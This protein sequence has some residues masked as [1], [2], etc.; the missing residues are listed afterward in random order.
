M[1][2]ASVSGLTGAPRGHNR[3][4]PNRRLVGGIA[5]FAI[6]AL[7]ASVVTILPSSAPAVRAA[8]P[9]I[10]QGK[11]ATCSSIENAGTACANAVD[12][13]TGTRWSSAFS[14][15]Q[16][17]QIDL[18]ATA[19][20]SQVILNWETAAG[21]SFTIQ[22]SA[23]ATTWTTIY[24]TTTGTGGI[25]TLAVTG[26]GRYVRMYGTVRTTGYGYSLWEFQ[27]FGILNPPPPTATPTRTAAPT[28]T[29]VAGCGTTNVALNK[30]ATASSIENA[31]TPASAAVDGN[32]GTRWSSA[33]SDPQ[34]L[35]VDLGSSQTICRVVLNWETAAGKSFQ[36]QVS[37]DA[38]NWTSIYST[39][40]GTGGIQ[41]LTVAGTGRYIRMYGTVRTTGYGYSLWE[42][43]VNSGV[44]GP[45]PTPVATPTTGPT[46]TSG[47]SSGV[48]WDNSNIPVA[49]QVMTFK[50]LNRTNGK[51]PDSQV[52]WSFNGIV[53][54]IAE[55]PTFDMPANSSGRMYFGLGVAPNA[56]NNSSYW[57]FIEFTIGPAQFNGNTT[58][59]DA[60]GLKLAMRLHNADGTEQTVG[61][62]L[63][64]FQ[65]DRTATFN[66]FVAA[67]PAEFKPC[68]TV[69][70]P[71][72]IPEPGGGCG[73][74][75][76]GVNQN[77]YNSY[78]DSMWANNGITIA[79]P[80]PNGSGLGAYP[81]LSAAIF[82]HVGAA[83]G[84]F[85]TNG[86]IKNQAL[87]ADPATFY[88]AA[89]AMY[90]AKFWHDNAYDGKAYGFPYD[91]VG[92]YSS[93]ISHANPQYML[94]AIGW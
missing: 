9:L 28:P 15:P 67:M 38:V 24:T 84:N 43:Q 88:T 13:N 58:R 31:G 19:S 55:A 72:R 30:P 56:A 21:K 8:D 18:G 90:Y 69:M 16:W 35:Q 62:N 20:V 68:G 59:V 45:T 53:H 26:S 83:A 34:W 49:T 11:V 33:F 89:P 75:A 54:S 41:T 10:S 5:A 37:A 61:E 92:G 3:A 73:F 6:A 85:N 78:I 42:F 46:P 22:T 40:T 4:A 48:F 81:D 50:F 66:R 64:T 23:N 36:I 60:F 77:Y 93:Y 12:G 27:V 44:L 86:T 82:R 1:S 51:Y 65:E 91:D 17:I 14:D 76:G 71:Y 70:A 29:P 47:P 25:Q 57:D 7:A 87:W 39:T 79:K 52:F 2:F 80:G 94:V 32:T 74:N 63:A